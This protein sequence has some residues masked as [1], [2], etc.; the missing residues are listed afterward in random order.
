MSDDGAGVSTSGVM[1]FDYGLV[2]GGD[3][4]VYSDHEFTVRVWVGQHVYAIQRSYSS[5]CFFDAALRR[6]YPR[7]KLPNLPLFGK[8]Q[9]QKKGLLLA[10]P[11]VTSPGG[12]SSQ[13]ESIIKDLRAS[14]SAFESDGLSGGRESAGR[15]SIRRV[16][17]TEVIQQKKIPLTLYLQ[18]LWTVPEILLSETLLAF[19]DEESPEGELLEEQSSPSPIDLLLADQVPVQKRVL[20][21]HSVALNVEEGFVIVWK[22]H[23]RSHDIG[24]SVRFNDADVLAY[25]R[26]N[27]HLKPVSGLFEVPAKG[28]VL[29]SFDNTYSRMHTKHLSY[30]VRVVEAGEYERA[31]EAAT[32]RAKEKHA[33]SQQRILLQRCLARL[34]RE[35]ISSSGVQFSA[36]S[37]SQ[38]A[39][40]RFR[41]ASTWEDE[42]EQ[43]R[44]EKTSLTHALEE[45]IR[46][47]EVERNAYADSIGQLESAS[48]VKE[49]AEE[50][51]RSVRAELEAL[52]RQTADEREQHAGAIEELK[53][54]RDSALDA[55]ALAR[56][57]M[58][59]AQGLR[60]QTEQLEASRAETSQLVEVVSRLK[61]EKRQ[62]VSF[63]KQAKADIERLTHE[64][65]MLAAEGDKLREELKAAGD[66][67]M[68]R[69][70]RASSSDHSLGPV[71]RAGAAGSLLG[72]WSDK[73]AKMGVFSP[74]TAAPPAPAA[75]QSSGARFHEYEFGF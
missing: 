51:L 52:Q 1:V 36:S 60:D 55:M 33:L 56:R 42:L 53:A 37:S 46:A 62:L 2:V 8:D 69:D 11:S 13:P 72:E 61:G 22:F 59:E 10:P 38:G 75:S 73:L 50:E 64:L 67:N 39:E 40:E 35:I 57:D 45:S 4:S 31:K 74:S 3:P 43:L 19:L 28:Q 15:R 26:V 18:Q 34:A 17:N 16:D 58:A 41:T 29:V 49:A 65:Q 25:Q 12:P 66:L 30:C 48:A 21:T 14:L 27:S 54:S 44:D 32:F 24:L 7:S 5:F 71:V 6:K 23:T 70:S 9:H 20:R 68:T 47:L 63:A